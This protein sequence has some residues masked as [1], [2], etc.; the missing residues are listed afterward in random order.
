MQTAVHYLHD[1]DAAEDV[2]QETLLKLFVMRPKLDA[3]RSVEALARTVVKHLSLN[4]IRDNRMSA[5]IDPSRI[6]VIDEESEEGELS[7]ERLRRTF[8]MIDALP[9]RQSIIMRMKHVEGMEVEEIAR[10]AGCSVDAV[11]ANL[12]RGRRAIVE[13]FKQ[14]GGL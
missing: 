3:Y 2:V 10:T 8:E 13:R 6:A 14:N 12:S 7:A 9:A 11:Y 4:Y 1:R 5:V